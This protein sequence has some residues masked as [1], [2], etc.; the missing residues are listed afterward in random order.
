MKPWAETSNTLSS[1]IHDVVI[2]SAIHSDDAPHGNPIG[3]ANQ[4]PILD[5]RIY[6]VTF[7]DGHTAEYTLN[8]IAECL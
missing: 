6:E 3:C 1:F 5:M 4:N 7:P 2:P 8:I